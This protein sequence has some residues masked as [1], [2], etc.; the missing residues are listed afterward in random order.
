[1][2]SVSPCTSTGSSITTSPIVSQVSRRRLLL[3]CVA[4]C[5]G[6]RISQ[7]VSKC[8]VCH[9]FKCFRHRLYQWPGLHNHTVCHKVSRLQTQLPC[10]PAPIIV[11]RCPYRFVSREVSRSP[12]LSSAWTNA[13]TSTLPSVSPTVSTFTYASLAAKLITIASASTSFNVSVFK[14]MALYF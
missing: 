13:L 12:P 10:Q 5:L 3:E 8:L 6:L 7:F 1:M 4:K 2:A 11:R 14:C 9:L